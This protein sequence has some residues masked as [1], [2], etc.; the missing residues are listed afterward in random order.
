MEQDITKTGKMSYRDLQKANELDNLTK[1]REK[2]ARDEANTLA[3]KEIAQYKALKQAGY[4]KPKT[5]NAMYT[6]NP[7]REAGIEASQVGL[8]ESQF[9]ENVHQLAQL[10]D[11]NE[12][13]A[14]YQ[15]ST[16]KIVNALAKGA[17]LAGTTFLNGTIGLAAGIGQGIYNVNDGNKNTGFL[18]GIW[19]N[20]FTNTMNALTEESEKILPNYYTKYEQEAPWQNNIF[21]AN[22]LG[23]KF[24][25]NL[26]FTVGAFWSG[27]IYS[28]ALGAGVKGF[29]NLLRSYKA[30]NSAIEKAQTVGKAFN[31][32]ISSGIAAINEGSTEALTNSSEWEKLETMKE[33]D[34]FKQDLISLRD[35]YGE[36]SDEFKEASEELTKDHNA[37]LSQ[38]QLD[39]AT[40]GNYDLK[41]NIPIL[42]IGNIIQFGRLFANGFK[43]SVKGFGIFRNA[44]G[45]TTTESVLKGLGKGVRNA[46]SEGTEEISQ[47]AASTISG[48]YASDDLNNYYKSQIDPN[49]EQ[50]TLSILDYIGKG[51]SDTVD[52]NSSWE[53]F[54]IGALTG[55]LGMPRFRKMTRADG[56]KQSPIVLDTGII[57]EMMNSYNRKKEA[58]KLI[59]KI[60]EFESNPDKQALITSF[61]QHMYEQ[62]KQDKAALEN[63]KYD[64]D[65][66]KFRDLFSAAVAYDRAGQL[67]Y[68]VQQIK[69]A[70]DLSDQDI[71][72][73]INTTTAPVANEEETAELKDLQENKIPELNESINTAINELNN[74][75]DTNSQE[76]EESLN[77]I[78]K[79]KDSLVEAENQRDALLNKTSKVISPFTDAHGNRKSNDE[80]RA[81]VKKNGDEQLEVIN[82]FIKSKEKIESA[83]PG[84]FTDEQI[85][86]LSW[87]DSQTEDWKERRAG[88]AKKVRPHLPAYIKAT[89]TNIEALKV[90]R[91]A[92][93]EAKQDTS[94]IDKKIKEQKKLL[95]LGNNLNAKAFLDERYKDVENN[96]EDVNS[97]TLVESVDTIK[98]ADISKP[99]SKEEKEQFDTD[100]NDYVKIDKGI[101]NYQIKLSEFLNN[102]SKLD[103]AHAKADKEI[104][105][106]VQNETAAK[107]LEQINWK[108]SI[109]EIATILDSNNEG[110]NKLGGIKAL[111]KF[112]PKKYRKRLW[113][114]YNMSDLKNRLSQDIKNS[115]ASDEAKN[116]ALGNLTEISNISKTPEDFIN[117]IGDNSVF[118]DREPIDTTNP[119]AVDRIE[120]A[121]AEARELLADRASKLKEHFE[122]TMNPPSDNTDVDKVPTDKNE[123]SYVPKD[124]E[125][126]E[127]KDEDKI[128]EEGIDEDEDIDFDE[129]DKGVSE[130]ITEEEAKELNGTFISDEEASDSNP[131]TLTDL[132]SQAK[133]SI[134]ISSRTKIG[135]DN[136][137][138]KY[139]NRPQISEMYLHDA[140]SLIKHYKDNPNDIPE[141]ADPEAFK[142]YVKAVNEY[143]IDKGAYDYIS[144][145]NKDKLRI[146]DEVFFTVDPTLNEDA[147][148]LV[149]LLATKNKKGETQIIGSMKTDIDWNS[150]NTRGVLN[151][152]ASPINYDLYQAIKEE[153]NEYKKSLG[154]QSKAGQEE[155]NK[156][157]SLEE[158]LKQAREESAKLEEINNEAREILKKKYH[159]VDKPNIVSEEKAKDESLRGRKQILRY[160]KE[161]EELSNKIDPNNLKEEDIIKALNLLSRIELNIERGAAIT[162]EEYDDF[163]KTLEFIKSEGYE[164]VTHQLDIYNDGMR[165]K[166]TMVE[167]DTLP[168]GSQVITKI[169]KPQ[170]NK[171]GKMIQAAEVTVSIGTK[172]TN[173]ESS[174]E[175]SKLETQLKEETKDVEDKEK[176][177]KELED[178]IKKDKELSKTKEG[179]EKEDLLDNIE[180]NTIELSNLK[181]SLKLSKEAL[182]DTK[183]QLDDLKNKKNNIGE[184]NKY[185]LIDTIDNIIK[186]ITPEIYERELDEAIIGNVKAEITAVLDYLNNKISKEQLLD[187]AGW[188]RITGDETKE[189]KGEI[190]NLVNKLIKFYSRYIKKEELNI[191][192]TKNPYSNLI[193]V[194]EVEPDVDSMD[195]MGPGAMF[196]IYKEGKY[197]GSIAIDA[198]Y[199]GKNKFRNWDDSNYISMSSVGDSVEINKEE[200]GKGYGKAAYFEFAKQIASLG[201]ILRSAP[202][203]SRTEA[204]TRVWKSLE[205]DGYAKKI[206]DRYEII[207]DNINYGNNKGPIIPPSRPEDKTLKNTYFE[208]NGKKVSANTTKIGSIEGYDIRV[209]I[210]PKE[211][212]ILNITTTSYNYYIVLPN[213]KTKEMMHA[214]ALLTKEQYTDAIMPVLQAHSSEIKAMAEEETELGKANNNSLAEA[215]ARQNRLNATNIPTNR[216]N[217]NTIGE[218]PTKLVKDDKPVSTSTWDKE[219]KDLS[220]RDVLALQ[221]MGC[222][223]TDWNRMSP[224]E[225][226]SEYNCLG[227]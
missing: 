92:A 199:L 212:K 180:G 4:I 74:I 209:Y 52:D 174:E 195:G 163:K 219:W 9:D 83:Y 1:Q 78:Y 145:M 173:D 170:I 127:P 186:S 88:I 90:I 53:E 210:E 21:T 171:N 108:A 225:R 43:P 65:N 99:L 122:N 85:A 153:Y 155:G 91:D 37:R 175:I 202:D 192:K 154:K 87:I 168:E 62:D 27:G 47:K 190:E 36:D 133:K 194:G 44:E 118:K 34:R 16:D 179:K 14:N 102:P 203:N 178:S 198:T 162:Q 41:F 159:I 227:I 142:K 69:D 23:D 12:A 81:Y 165:V 117:K 107:I 48:Y 126:K 24:L 97:S 207:N 121:N 120:R 223:S 82:K 213:G 221:A 193:T 110:I 29:S 19:D 101:K 156:E 104:D 124:K 167:D 61:V 137:G 38:I 51:I 166:T 32:V 49:A 114:A 222:N 22:W 208:L 115:D 123:P 147:G 197:I 169:D 132:Q 128:N 146:G 189:E 71:E 136:K 134:F 112:T 8:G 100:L 185:T 131:T 215:R 141:G 172:S 106:Q 119:D 59:N 161:L 67:E 60:Q 94:D 57:G 2:K 31:S 15:S 125:I 205:R 129:E 40:M 26:G 96:D 158:Q 76:Y 93:K 130:E 28:K 181:D 25:K 135:T 68:L 149:V 191:D 5:L 98:D 54:T 151:K 144:G 80:I 157:L 10:D 211:S 56:K 7:Y 45:L 200:R 89:R 75:E 103:E 77:N 196:S 17:L 176:R 50:K 216:G 105:N 42:T 184:D 139:D 33:N 70:S 72:D 66:S 218:E 217:I 6:S 226:E 152:E 111:Y 183:K 95:R 187:N 30:A 18:Q 201:K 20:P 143:L 35:Y 3:K 182:E 164:I 177:I 109:N 58:E 138:Y 116:I 79:L 11:L 160:T 55:A 63:N 46:A 64:F 220:D 148:T 84:I 73:L 39:K 13:R 206:N 113:N 150:K 188:V 86:E 224:I 204:S 140:V 214:Q